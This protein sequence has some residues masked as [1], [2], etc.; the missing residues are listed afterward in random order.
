MQEQSDASTVLS[1]SIHPNKGHHRQ[2]HF[3]QIDFGVIAKQDLCLFHAVNTFGDGRR[4]KSDTLPQFL[5]RETSVFLKEPEELPPNIIQQFLT[6]FGHSL[7][8]PFFFGR[9]LKCRCF[10]LHFIPF[11]LYTSK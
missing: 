8:S 2:A 10:F 9:S 11:C 4:S 1:S 7:F 5:E 3:L 6:I